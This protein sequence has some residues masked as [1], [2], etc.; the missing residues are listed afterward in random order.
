METRPAR[1]HPAVSITAA[2]FAAIAALALAAPRLYA[3]SAVPDEGQMEAAL[4]NQPPVTT[5]E[6][7]TLIRIMKLSVTGD[8][9][10][11]QKA[12]TMA[13]QAN[14]NEQRVIFLTLKCSAALLL[15]TESGLTPELAGQMLGDSR[16]IPT[17]EEMRAIEPHIDDLVELIGNA[18]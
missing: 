15:K 5:E 11:E 6:V 3:Q 4:A 8:P 7:G 1:P 9:D 14:L 12:K 17:D 13:E 10:A 18:G 16:V 2:A